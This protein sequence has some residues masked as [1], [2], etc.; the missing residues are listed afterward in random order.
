MTTRG[1]FPAPWSRNLRGKRLA[2]V[3]GA[4][5]CFVSRLGGITLHMD[6]AERLQTLLEAC[7]EVLGGI[8]N[9]ETR[10]LRRFARCADSLRSDC[11]NS[12]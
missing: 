12:E 2:L 10:L 1:S 6:E 9:R 8:E 7:H 11:A 3:A 4:G 5:A